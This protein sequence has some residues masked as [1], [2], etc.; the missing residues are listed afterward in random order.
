MFLSSSEL[1]IDRQLLPATTSS[2]WEIISAGHL[3]LLLCPTCEKRNFSKLSNWYSIERH[4]IW[5][6]KEVRVGDDI[7]QH[8]LDLWS[9]HCSSNLRF[10]LGLKLKLHLLPVPDMITTLHISQCQ[11]SL[12]PGLYQPDLTW[13]NGWSHLSIFWT[14][15]TIAY[16][17]QFDVHDTT[18]GLSKQKDIYWIL[19][20]CSININLWCHAEQRAWYI[21]EITFI[22][23]VMFSSHSTLLSFKCDIH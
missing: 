2:L 13:H 22:L 18:S 8:S 21:L 1:T 5:S 4:I 15:I 23:V 11:P 16:Y 10:M 9:Q 6:C 17:D 20:N 12:W 19:M 7:S 14:I 3:S